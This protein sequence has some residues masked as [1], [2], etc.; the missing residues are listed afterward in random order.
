MPRR[1]GSGWL[2]ENSRATNWANGATAVF[3]NSEAVTAEIAEE[4]VTATAVRFAG[5]ARERTGGKLTLMSDAKIVAT[6]AADVPTNVPIV[7]TEGRAILSKKNTE[8][9]YF[10]MKADLRVSPVMNL[11]EVERIDVEI[12]GAY[13]NQQACPG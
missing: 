13:V 11:K 3:T 1:A 2:P 10:L 9:P 7:G 12:S 8:F 4:G 5:A 6:N